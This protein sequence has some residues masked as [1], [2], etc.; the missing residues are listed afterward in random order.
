MPDAVSEWMDVV[1]RGDVEVEQRPRSRRTSSRHGAQ[2]ACLM[3]RFPGAERDVLFGA[4]RGPRSAVDQRAG[5]VP[6]RHGCAAREL[7]VAQRDSRLRGLLREEYSSCAPSRRRHPW[8]RDVCPQT[9]RAPARQI[10][11]S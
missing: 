5:N 4:T 8:A 9:W 3:A 6:L 2:S 7:L 10:P 11:T 1:E